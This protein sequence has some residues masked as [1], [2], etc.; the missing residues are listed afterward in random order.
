MEQRALAA[1]E[2]DDIQSLLDDIGRLPPDSKLASLRSSARC[3]TRRRLP[4]DHGV[5]PIYRH[6]G[7]SFARNSARDPDLRLLCFSGRGGEVSAA[8]GTWR[9][10]GRDDAK[11]RFRNGEADLLLCTDAAAE[12]LNF[13]FCGALVNYDMPWNPMRVEQRIGRIDRLGQK[14]PVIRIINLHYDG[15][16]RDRRLPGAAQTH[17]PV[18]NGGRA[19]ATDSCTASARN[20]WRCAL[21]SRTRAGRTCQRRGRLLSNRRAKLSVAASTSTMHWN[22][23]V[24][25][26][27]SG[28]PSPILMEDLDRVISS[29]GL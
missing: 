21:W 1:E 29:R 15:Y 28:S 2:T 24:T 8:D 3:A 22:E 20:R 17:R 16:R 10:I 9:R 4:A 14:Y 25:M 13:Q 11:R 27:D 7:L 26:P 12:G 19:P 23:D 6:H 5:H 18:R